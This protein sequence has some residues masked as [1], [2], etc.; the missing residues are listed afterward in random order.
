MHPQDQS[1][2]IGISHESH[3]SLTSLS[4]VTWFTVVSL[5]IYKAVVAN[6]Y[7]HST[8]ELNPK[9]QVVTDQRT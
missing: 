1:K 7:F 6:D 3:K 5:S 8:T 4:L 9:G 2:I